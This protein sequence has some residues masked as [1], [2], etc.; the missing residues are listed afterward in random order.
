MADSAKIQNV[1]KKLGDLGV[2]ITIDNFGTGPTSLSMLKLWPINQLKL[3]RS[4]ISSLPGNSNDAALV[5]ATLALA[6]NFKLD[7]VAEG[8]ET[9]EQRDFLIQEGCLQ[10]QGYLFSHPISHERI[11][12]RLAA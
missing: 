11:A 1:L 2:G 6:K 9:E 8:I 5:R 3:D 12:E 10:G 7:V 4:I